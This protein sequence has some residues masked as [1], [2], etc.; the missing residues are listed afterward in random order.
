MLEHILPGEGYEVASAASGEA[1]IELARTRPFDLALCDIM[2]PG[3]DGLDTLRALKSLRP[4]TE[5]VMV[6]GYATLESAV[7]AMKLGAYD[8]MTKPFNPKILRARVQALF[9]RG[10][11]GAEAGGGG[12]GGTL[13]RRPLGA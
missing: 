5:V 12:G 2:M 9:R 10:E 6:T 13:R 7:E 11:Y 3:I 4:R 1:A 8:Y